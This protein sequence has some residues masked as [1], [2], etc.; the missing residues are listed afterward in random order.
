MSGVLISAA[1]TITVLM[2]PFIYMVRG[3]VAVGFRMAFVICVVLAAV[4]APSYRVGR[5]E[6]Y[7]HSSSVRGDMSVMTTHEARAQARGGRNLI[8]ASASLP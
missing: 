7:E 5:I 2:A 4:V 1:L 6:H 3:G 8:A